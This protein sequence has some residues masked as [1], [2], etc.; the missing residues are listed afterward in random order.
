MKYSKLI[1][2]YIST[3]TEIAQL[4]KLPKLKINNKNNTLSTT[5]H[6]ESAK[7]SP[8]GTTLCIEI[9]R[10]YSGYVFI[11]DDQLT[12]DIPEAIKLAKFI[13]THFNDSEELNGDDINYVPLPK[14]Y[15]VTKYTPKATN[16][17]SCIITA[18][19]GY[20]ND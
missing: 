9:R 3:A 16:L 15:V 10:S 1:T 6:D 18:V 12:I 14:G 7:G 8:L 4:P 5:I 2:K 13:N 11:R 19:K 20:Y 17:I